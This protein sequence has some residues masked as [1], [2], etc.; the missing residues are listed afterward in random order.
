MSAVSPSFFLVY[1][2]H[3]DQGDGELTR[4]PFG[5]HQQNGM[6]AKL[7]WAASMPTP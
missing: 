6:S 5:S 1:S 3:H 7:D 4:S 2:R